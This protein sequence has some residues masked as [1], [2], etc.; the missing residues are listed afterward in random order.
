MA[1]DEKFEEHGNAGLVKRRSGLADGGKVVVGP[2]AAKEAR[3][4]R[5]D[6][7]SGGEKLFWVFQG[8]ESQRL[9]GVRRRLWEIRRRVRFA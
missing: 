7:L 6:C 5:V 8:K 2:V 3:W 4:E 9:S 1:G